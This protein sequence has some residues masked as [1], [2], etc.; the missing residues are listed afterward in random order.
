MLVNFKRDFFSASGAYYE[1]GTREYN[2]PVED[3]AGNSLLPSDAVIVSEDG[4]LPFQ[5]NSPI[6]KPGFGAKPL[7]EQVLDM[8]P[9]AGDDH[10]IHAADPGSAPTP[11]TQEQKEE[12]E[13]AAGEAAVVE[14][15]DEQ[16]AADDE[17]AKSV[18][19]SLPAAEAAAEEVKKIVDPISG[20]ALGGDKG[21]GKK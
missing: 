11:L 8:I 13:K 1:A 6:P 17:L 18:E 3:K 14:K 16:K 4:S 7:E 19:D 21:K 2:G 20:L 12:K 15:T 10:Q 5:P 9:G